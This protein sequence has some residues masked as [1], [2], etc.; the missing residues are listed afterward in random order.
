[1]GQQTNKHIK[2]K[3][4]VAYHQR[5]NARHK[6]AAKSK[7]KK[8]SLPQRQ[9]A[10]AAVSDRRFL[11]RLF[12]VGACWQLIFSDIRLYRLPRRLLHPRP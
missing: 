9:P 3:R 1:M 6:A 12:L 2:K 8:Y 10:V 11:F 7:S 5:R 4:R